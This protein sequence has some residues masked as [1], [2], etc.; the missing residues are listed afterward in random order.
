MLIEKKCIYCNYYTVYLPVCEVV[1]ARSHDSKGNLGS[2][3]QAA[4][5][6]PHTEEVSLCNFLLLN[7]KQVGSEAVN[8]N[9]YNLWFYPTLI[10]PQSTLYRFSS[11]RSIY[12]TTDQHNCRA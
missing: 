12:S 6:S 11:R 2:S 4:T 8:T 5:C 3:S 1:L 9:F 7:I 10:E